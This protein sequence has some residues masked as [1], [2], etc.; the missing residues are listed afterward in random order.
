[1]EKEEAGFKMEREEE[2]G[3]KPCKEETGRG[4]SG[5]RRPPGASRCYIKE[6]LVGQQRDGDLKIVLFTL[7]AARKT[8]KVHAI[9]CNT[10]QYHAIP[11]NTMQ[12]HAIP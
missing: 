6:V 4:T 11:G 3:C 5:G 7:R 2:L 12:Y 1:M 8:V 9:P 10:V